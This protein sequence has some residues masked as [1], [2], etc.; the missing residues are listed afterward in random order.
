[1]NELADLCASKQYRTIMCYVIQRE[2]V[3]SFQPSVIDP[4]YREAFYNARNKGVEMRPYNSNGTKMV[5]PT[6]M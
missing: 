4:I 1:M 3:S 5:I 2:D 6:N